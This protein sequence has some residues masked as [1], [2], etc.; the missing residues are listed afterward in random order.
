MAAQQKNLPTC[1]KKIG[2]VCYAGDALFSTNSWQ[3]KP[4]GPSE[5]NLPW[6]R[7]IITKCYTDLLNKCVIKSWQSMIILMSVGLPEKDCLCWHWLTFQQPEQKSSSQS[8]EDLLS[9]CR[10]VSQC[11]HKQS[12]SG[13]HSPGRSYFTGLW[14][15]FWVQTIYKMSVMSDHQ[16]CE[17][18]WWI[19]SIFYLMVCQISAQESVSLTV[20]KKVTKKH[21][22]HK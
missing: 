2:N 14:C 20:R 4:S 16:Q 21:W 3:F 19:S 10:N 1:R 11:H 17:K 18:L 12:F 15:V 7:I 5:Y 13:L 22:N 8:R 6:L 9:C